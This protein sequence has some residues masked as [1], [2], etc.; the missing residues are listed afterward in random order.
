MASVGDSRSVGSPAPETGRYL[1]A[2][3]TN[4]ENFIK[5]SILPLCANPRCPNKGANWVLQEK[6]LSEVPPVP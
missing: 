5:G 1:H 2:A 3:C 6:A 4:S